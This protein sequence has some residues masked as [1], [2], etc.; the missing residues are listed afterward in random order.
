MSLEVGGKASER[1]VSSLCAK[2]VAYCQNLS[3]DPSLYGQQMEKFG[4]F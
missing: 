2:R 4:Y 1:T 3:R